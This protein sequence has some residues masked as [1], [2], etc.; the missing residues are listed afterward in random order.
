MS[1]RIFKPGA[2][3]VINV[4]LMPLPV[5]G[6]VIDVLVLE[7]DNYYIVYEEL[8]TECLSHHYNAYEVSQHQIPSFGISRPSDFTDNCLP[9]IYR[10]QSSMFI[11]RKYNIV[12]E[13]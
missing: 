5:F 4:D 12:E 11:P 2:V 9:G 6:V 3:I 13:T 8:D 1:G 10:K 7:V